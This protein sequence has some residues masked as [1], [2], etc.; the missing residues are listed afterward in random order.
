[1]AHGR[2]LGDM[3]LDQPGGELAGQRAG[4]PFPLIEGDELILLIGIEHQLEDGLGLLEPL[5]PQALARG[6]SR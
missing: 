6:V 5:T 4:A 2:V 3:L 1:V